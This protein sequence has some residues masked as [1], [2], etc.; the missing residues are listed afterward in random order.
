MPDTK[1]NNDLLNAAFDDE[2]IL[3]ASIHDLKRYL[4]ACTEMREVD[5]LN[6]R[7]KE[8]IPKR[9]ALIRHFISMH[10]AEVSH[11]SL[12]IRSTWTIVISFATLLI[13]ILTTYFDHAPSSSG[14]IPQSQVPQFFENKSRNIEKKDESLIQKKQQ[15]T[16]YAE[17]LKVDSKLPVQ[18]ENGVIWED[19]FHADAID[20]LVYSYIGKANTDEVKDNAD[21]LWNSPEIQEIKDLGFMDITYLWINTSTKK[22]WGLYSSKNRQ[23]YQSLDEYV[24]SR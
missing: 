14:P 24:K 2:T 17:C 20:T 13:L 11:R 4:L 9:E 16:D 23:W 1:R 3:S 18:L 5:I 8:G 12:K 22:E 6:E 7:V 10:Q 21:Q 15:R 19:V